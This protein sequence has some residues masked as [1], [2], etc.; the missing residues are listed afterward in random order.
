MSANTTPIFL[1][2]PNIQYAST[3]T[4]ANTLFDGTGTVTTVFTAD[5]TNGSKVET[6]TLQNIGS[7]VATVVRFFLNNGSANSVA[8]NNALLAEVTWATNVASQVASSQP[9]VIN[10]NQVM[11]PSYKLNCTIGTAVASGIMVTVSGGDY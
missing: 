10:L 7:N 8:A 11:K 3:G 9:V 5:A 6:V 4:T 2:Q 1:K